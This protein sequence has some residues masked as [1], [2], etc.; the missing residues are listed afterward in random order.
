MKLTYK[1][2]SAVQIILASAEICKKVLLLDCYIGVTSV[3][4]RWRLGLGKILLKVSHK[5]CSQHLLGLLF[6]FWPGTVHRIVDNS[7]A[8]MLKKLEFTSC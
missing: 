7:V 4:S 8:Y 1:G 6:T 3:T 2:H 5:I